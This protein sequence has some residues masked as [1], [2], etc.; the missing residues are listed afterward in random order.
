MNDQHTFDAAPYVLGAL[1]E[2]ERQA[3]EVHMQGCPACAAEVADF[4]E[5]PGLLAQIPADDPALTPT[6]E[7]L[8]PPET[9]L[10]TLL[11]SVRRER[12]RRRWRVAAA[13]GLVAACLAGLGTAVVL[14][15]RTIRPG[16]VPVPAALAFQPVG[17]APAPV[18]ATATLSPRAWGTEVRVTCTY[19][20]TPWSDGRPRT[21]K[22]VLFGKEGQQYPAVSDWTVLPDQEVQ[23]TAST[24]VPRDQL[25]RLEIRTATDKPVL[26]L[27]L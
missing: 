1:S 3:F 19:S 20:G 4:A 27:S 26:E 12:R 17:D 21:Y 11:H 25:G 16:S 2:E 9:L 24:A 5:L 14:D 15:Q 22:L 10:P 7:Q 18:R 8:E 13:T 6:D 23:M